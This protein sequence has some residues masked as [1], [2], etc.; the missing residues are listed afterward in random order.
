MDYTFSI[1]FA[2]GDCAVNPESEYH[3]W[4]FM[5]K[6]LR[7]FWKS[8]ILVTIKNNTGVSST[9]HSSLHY[10]STNTTAVEPPNSFLLKQFNRRSYVTDYNS[11]VILYL[12]YNKL[13]STNISPNDNSESL[14]GY[15]MNYQPL[16][17]FCQLT[18][19]PSL[20]ANNMRPH[21]I[22]RGI[23]RRIAA[24]IRIRPRSAFTVAR[25]MSA[26]P[27]W[28]CTCS[29]I[30]LR[31]A[32]VYAARCSRGPGCCKVTCAATPARSRTDVPTA[33]RLSPIVR[34]CERTCR[35]IQRTRTMSALSATSRS[36]SS[37]T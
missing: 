28:R 5:H 9:K 17:I 33:A 27:L 32:A 35:R 22:Y 6:R 1:R 11:T 24:S 2:S 7:F 16:S 34:I 13:G 10:S 36:L 14:C 4:V 20:Q 23:S 3:F 12:L 31:T 29:R 26:C 19:F 25:R 15:Y 30:S 37:R 18:H 8:R 21:R